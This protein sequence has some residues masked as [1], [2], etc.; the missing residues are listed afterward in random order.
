MFKFVSFCVVVL[1]A[2]NVNA[3]EINAQDLNLSEEQNQ[4][5]TELKE[6]MKAE[7]EPIWAEIENRRQQITDIEKKYFSEFWNMLS[8]EQRQKFA[9][10]NKQ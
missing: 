3:T 1:W 7:I 5:L 9:E 4:R 2:L 6:N 10:I 8:E